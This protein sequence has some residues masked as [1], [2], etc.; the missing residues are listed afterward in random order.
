VPNIS[1]G[2]PIHRGG[3]LTLV[4]ALWLAADPPRMD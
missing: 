3:L 2:S 4:P 1:T